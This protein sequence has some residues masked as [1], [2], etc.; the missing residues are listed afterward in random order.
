MQIDEKMIFTDELSD[1]ALEGAA[2]VE[3]AGFQLLC[4]ELFFH[5]S[6]IQY[7]TAQSPSVILRS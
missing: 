6:G 2:F 3:L 7:E 5:V 1:A 4:L